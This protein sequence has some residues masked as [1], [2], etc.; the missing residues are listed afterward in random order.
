MGKEEHV[1]IIVFSETLWGK[2]NRLTLKLLRYVSRLCRN[3]ARFER[4]GETP[5][6]PVRCTPVDLFPQTKNVELI[7][8]FDRV[9]KETPVAQ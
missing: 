4:G 9:S 3:R 6:V 7:F 2:S 1:E 8:V 5:F